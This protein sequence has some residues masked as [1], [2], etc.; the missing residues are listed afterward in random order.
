MSSVTITTA[1]DNQTILLFCG[2]YPNG[3]CYVKVNGEQP[4]SLGILNNK[5]FTIS[6]YSFFAPSAG[7]YFVNI[8]SQYTTT[9]NYAII[10]NGAGKTI[11]MFS[12]ADYVIPG[13]ANAN[14]NYARGLSRQ[15]YTTKDSQLALSMFVAC[16]NQTGAYPTY[17][18]VRSSLPQEVFSDHQGQGF[19]VSV[20]S[21]VVQLPSPF[22]IAVNTTSP[23]V[24]G[25]DLITLLLEPDS[26]ISISFQ[27]IGAG[28]QD[29]PLFSVISTP[30]TDEYIESV[31]FKY[32][33]P[34]SI[35]NTYSNPTQF[36]NL[37]GYVGYMM[38]YLNQEIV[39]AP[40]T[41]AN[42]SATVLCQDTPSLPVSGAYTLTVT[43][44]DSGNNQVNTQ[45]NYIFKPQLKEATWKIPPRQ[46]YR[47]SMMPETVYE[48]GPLT[49]ID[50]GISPNTAAPKDTITDA[51]IIVGTSLE[52]Q[53]Q[54]RYQF[55]QNASPWHGVPSISGG[56][57]I[58]CSMN[59]SQFSLGQKYFAYCIVYDS[60]LGEWSPISRTLEFIVTQKGSSLY[61]QLQQIN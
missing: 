33:G 59:I 35:T 19:D 39:N 57:L 29:F 32:D 47:T 45:T 51:I 16:T 11:R 49:S 52:F 13:N 5:T 40:N 6:V 18:N 42:M 28:A 20:T 61:L 54:I 14:L 10:I 22:Y 37:Y 7:S 44:L 53:D 41:S 26:N 60:E 9:F 3:T 30:S 48:Y 23:T 38:T 27:K 43:A 1:V 12:S 4:N 15:V 56:N 8:T 58:T 46:F 17:W 31:I 21:A 2:G 25:V 36:T 50:L 24:F 34:A 55:S